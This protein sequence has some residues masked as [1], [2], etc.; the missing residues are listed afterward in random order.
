MG[1]GLLDM[2]TFLVSGIR[3]SF[4]EDIVWLLER[5]MG[6]LVFLLNV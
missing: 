3:Q 5:M 1:K 2:L 6:I 4:I